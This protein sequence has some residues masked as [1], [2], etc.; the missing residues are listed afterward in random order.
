MN[1]KIPSKFTFRRYFY[2]KTLRNLYITK[3]LMDLLST[4]QSLPQFHPT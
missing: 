4:H 1:K 2:N 3:Y